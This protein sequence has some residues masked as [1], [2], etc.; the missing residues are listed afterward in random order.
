MSGQPRAF[1]QLSMIC[2]IL[3]RLSSRCT[4]ASCTSPGS[5]SSTDVVHPAVGNSGN[6]HKTAL[7]NS[8]RVGNALA[9]LRAWLF[10]Y[11]AYT[12]IDIYLSNG[13]SPVYM[14]CVLYIY[15]YTDIYI[16]IYTHTCIHIHVQ[17]L[18][19][20]TCIDILCMRDAHTSTHLY[21]LVNVHIK[22]IH[23]IL[24]CICMILHMHYVHEFLHLRMNMNMQAT[25]VAVSGSFSSM[26]RNVF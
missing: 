11:L 20:Y 4:I 6:G 18:H 19:V 15:R 2:F 16:Y 21:R 25:S 8:R 24:M 26:H 23:G 14:C 5:A 17:I 7:S 10:S 9:C 22:C 1:Q 12:Y 3:R 13:M